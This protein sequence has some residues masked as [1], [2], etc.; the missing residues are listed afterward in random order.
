M[1]VGGVL[2]PGEDAGG[3]EVGIVEDGVAVGIVGGIFHQAGGR[4]AGGGVDGDLDEF[5][6]V[7]QRPDEVFA[8]DRTIPAAAGFG[9]A[10]VSD[11]E[12]FPGLI[13]HRYKR[14]Q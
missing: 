5:V 3:G 7:G 14:G 9:R 8:G 13:L 10:R 11:A 4:G 2:I 6:D 1:E 12:F